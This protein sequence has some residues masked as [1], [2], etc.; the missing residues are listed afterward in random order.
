MISQIGKTVPEFS[1]IHP[2]NRFLQFNTE[3][4]QK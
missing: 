3:I 2:S 4:R 1:K